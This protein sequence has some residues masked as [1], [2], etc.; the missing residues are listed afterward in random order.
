MSAVASPSLC[1]S[2]LAA[3]DAVL[4]MGLNAIRYKAVYPYG[5]VVGCQSELIVRGSGFL[6]GGAL[7]PPVTCSFGSRTDENTTAATVLNDTA[8]R[9]IN[10]VTPTSLGVLPMRVDWGLDPDTLSAQHVDQLPGFSAF[11]VTAN[12]IDSVRPG[13]GAYQ[14]TASIDVYGYLEDYG[15]PGCRFGS[16]FGPWAVVY[17]SSYARCEK[18]PFPS[19][20]R[21]ITAAYPIF[22]GNR[23]CAT[24]DT[25]PSD[26]LAASPASFR[27]YNAQI[28]SLSR[29]TNPTDL[30]TP[31]SVFGE[32]IVYPSAI[33]AICRFT[34]IEKSYD[35]VWG[36]YPAVAGDP[37][38]MIITEAVAL[39]DTELQCPPPVI[40]VPRVD[41]KLRYTVETLQNAVNIDPTSIGRPFYLDVYHVGSLAIKVISPRAGPSGQEALLTIHTARES[42]V[43]YGHGQLACVVSRNLTDFDTVQRH[44]ERRVGVERVA[45]RRR[46]ECARHAAVERE[47]DVHEACARQLLGAQIAVHAAR[48][49][50]QRGHCECAATGSAYGG[51]PVTINGTGSLQHLTDEATR[52]AN[53]RCRFGPTDGRYRLT[54]CKLHG[55]FIDGETQLW[56]SIWSMGGTNAPQRTPEMLCGSMG[57]AFCIYF[58][59]QL[60]TACTVLSVMIRLI[61][62]HFANVGSQTRKMRVDELEDVQKEDVR[63]VW[64]KYDLKGTVIVPSHNLLA[65]AQQL[66]QPLLGLARSRRS[67]TH[68]AK[69]YAGC[70]EGLHRPC[71]G[72]MHR[73]PKLLANGCTC[74][75]TVTP[76]GEASAKRRHLAFCRAAHTYEHSCSAARTRA[77]AHAS[78]RPPAL[79]ADRRR[80]GRAR[81]R[82]AANRRGD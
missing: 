61:L 78:R 63:K 25:E 35:G 36:P 66:K 30:A 42:V 73:A 56:N 26:A 41:V 72:E 9:C 81:R 46:G 74:V 16:W 37:S 65:I 48:A 76:S 4:Q 24:G 21:G 71:H 33:D 22:S 23:Q 20:E 70:F 3:C 15:M 49:D 32:G 67:L 77:H 40:D 29:Y 52:Y 17:N 1:A 5:T 8:V 6:G 12:R 38:S 60:L 79:R 54:C 64:L 75:T 55:P 69:V 68:P 13:A 14:D 10:S 39:S 44:V 59:L 34:R 11:D 28:N 82:L 45:N 31:I 53:L 80:D 47:L 19:S 7:S 27:T 50:E 57:A 2:P 18:P 58:G 43:D 51:Y 62:A